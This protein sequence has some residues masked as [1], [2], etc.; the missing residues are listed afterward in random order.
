MLPAVGYAS[1][2][3]SCAVYT[4]GTWHLAR[5]LGQGGIVPTPAVH[6]LR[7]QRE[8]PIAIQYLHHWPSKG[9]AGIQ[10]QAWE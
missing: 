5:G 8:H 4:C 6:A 9:C 2:Q 7:Q 10:A 1:G 3:M